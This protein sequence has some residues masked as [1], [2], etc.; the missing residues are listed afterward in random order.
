MNVY[1]A[2]VLSPGLAIGKVFFREKENFSIQ[3]TSIQ[4]QEI[5][6]ELEKF[7][8]TVKE[9]LEEIDHLIQDLGYSKEN[10][11]IL[12]THKLILKDPELSQKIRYSIEKELFSLEK[13][14]EKHF[15]QVISLFNNMNNKYFSQRSRDYEDVGNRL[16]RNILKKD[17]Q[18]VE[19]I[20][21]N[22]ILFT[23]IIQP[24]EMT[25]FFK[26]KIKGICVSHCS[27]NSHA[28]I[29]AR[30][31]N[32]PL[33]LISE[34]VLKN[35]KNGEVAIL[36]TD[37]N[38]ILINPDIGDIQEYQSRVVFQSEE[39]ERLKT[40]IDLPSITKDN[41]K[42][43]LLSNIEIP[44]EL[45]IVLSNKSDGIGLFRTEFLFI[46]REDLPSEEEQ[47]E[48]YRS[49]GS[50]INPNPVV[51]RTIDIGGDKLSKTLNLSHEANPN[52]G[53]RGIRFSLQHK[54]IFKQQI[55]A[56]LRANTS[57]NIQMMFPMIS[58]LSEFL[59]AKSVVMECE[60]ELKIKNKIK[61]GAMIE[62]PSA[63]ICSDQLAGACDFF[64]IGTNDLIQ[65]TLAVDRDNEAV[66]SYYNAA[67]YAVIRLI[68]MTIDNAHEHSIPVAICGEMASHPE[69]LS[70]LIGLG[71]DEISV[72]CGNFFKVKNFIR[73]KTYSELKQFAE[74]IIK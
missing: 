34:S 10:K 67:N 6:K 57:G 60:E 17:D 31:M 12:T 59:E 15:K 71:I 49:I 69:H 50:K 16:L 70:L 4:K 39:R 42:I 53:L 48:V 26:N 22:S 27:Y 66:A 29:I 62:V 25:H 3:K 23:E 46:D 13:S 20:D 61:I 35:C 72:S 74:D 7:E 51:I 11:E 54:E 14:V 8:K 30:S 44:E 5:K 58:S 63:A 38:K 9:V 45:D 52:L 55:R 47:Y 68:K 64:S 19:E 36:D 2:E 43:K 33:L 1:K 56:I 37:S 41:H 32:L 73:N 24:S 21:E 28:A 40:L 65:Y 18:K